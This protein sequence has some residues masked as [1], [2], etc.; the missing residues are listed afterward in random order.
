[1]REDDYINFDL[2][3]NKN[4]LRI[5]LKLRKLKLI[6]LVPVKKNVSNTLLK[7]Y[8]V[9]PNAISC[10]KIW[11]IPQ[12]SFFLE[13][14]PEA[15]NGGVLKNKDVLKNFTKFTGKQPCQSLF[16]D[17]FVGLRSATL[18]KKGLWHRCF[19]LNF[20]NFLRTPFL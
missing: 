1:M 13:D 12:I 14:F 8:P 11:Y 2:E 6:F 17:K 18:I 5:L 7:K 19:P 9:T 4:N 15:T 3:Q 20:V 16:F 10:T